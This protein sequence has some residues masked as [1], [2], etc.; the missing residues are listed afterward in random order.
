MKT[1]IHIKLIILA[2]LAFSSASAQVLFE[3]VTDQAGPFHRG[4]SW[5]ATW[6]DFNGDN[7]PDII[8]N[9]HRHKNSLWRNDCQGSFDDVMLTYDI[10]RTFI[11]DTNQDT[12]SMTVADVDNDGDQDLLSLRSSSGGRGQLFIYN[13]SYGDEQ[14]SSWD[15]DTC[16]GGRL[17]A[18]FDYDNDG[19]L[20]IFCARAGDIRVYRRNSNNTFSRVESTVG[21]QGQCSHNNYM[22]FGNFY[23]PSS[24]LDLSCGRL[25]TVPE[26]FYDMSTIPFNNVTSINS[27]NIS[28]VPDTVFADFDNDLDVDLFALKNAVRPSGA[29]RINS[30]KIESWIAVDKKSGQTF[31]DKGFRFTATGNVT[32]TYSGISRITNA[33]QPGKVYIGSSGYHPGSFPAVLDPTNSSNQG[34]SNSSSVGFFIGY[35]PVAQEWTALLRSPS[36]H[37][38]GYFVLDGTNFSEP[39]MFNLDNRDL[40]STPRMHTNNNGTLSTLFG[41]GFNEDISCGSIAAGDLDNDMDI[42]LY[43]ACRSGVENMEN[44]IYW[45]DGDGTF[46]K[47]SNHGGE[48]PVGAGLDSH[49]G[50]AESVVIADYDTDG[51][52]DLFVTN[53]NLLMPSYTGGPDVL[54]RN[55]G[56]NGNHWIELDLVGTNSNR[57]GIGAK[58]TATAGGVTQLREQNGGYHRDSQDHMR[59][60]FGLG[61]NTSVSVTVDWPDGSS[62]TYN[63]SDFTAGVD[64]LY[65]L[66]QGGNAVVASVGPMVDFPAPQPGD[67]CGSQLFES[68]SSRAIHMYKDC[69]SGIWRLRAVSGNSLTTIGYSG[70]IVSS[71][72]ITNVTGFSLEGS[73]VVNQ[74]TT[75][76]VAFSL[77]M[78]LTG[79]DGFDFSLTP[80][81]SSCLNVDLPQGAQLF[82]GDGYHLPKLPFN[83]ETLESCL[84][85]TSS[86]VTVSEAAGVAQVDVTLLG[87]SNQTI[88]VDYQTANGSATAG[89]DYTSGSG[90]L[91]FNPGDTVKSFN[92]PIINDTVLEGDETFTVAFSNAAGASLATSSITVTIEDNDSGPSNC[93]EPVIDTSVDRELFIWK[94]CAGNGDWH[95]LAT[96]GGGSVITYEGNLATDQTFSNV[97][98]VSIESSDVLDDSDPQQIIFKMKMGDVYRDGFNFSVAPGSTCLTLDL[99]SGM[100]VLVGENRTPLTSP[101]NIETLGACQTGLGVGDITVSE[102]D[103]SANVPVTLSSASGSIVTVEFQTVNGSATAGLDYT[104]GSGTVMFNPGET[105][106]SVNITILQDTAIEG[107]ENFTVQLSNPVNALISDSSGVV[108]IN[109]DDGNNCGEPVIDR[110]VDREI[111]IWQDCNDNEWHLRAYAGGGSPI[112]YIGNLTTFDSFTDVGLYSIESSDVVDTSDPKV[113]AFD[114]TMGD[115]WFDGIDFQVGVG[116]TCLTLNTPVGKDVLVGPNRQPVASPFDIK[117]LGACSSGGNNPPVVVNPGAQTNTVGASVSLFISATD[118][119]GDSLTYSQT[120]LPAGLDI[121]SGTGEITGAASSVGTS[122]VTVTASDGIASDSENFVWTIEQLPNVAPTANAG[123]N[124]TIVLPASVTLQGSASDDGLPNPPGAVTYSWSVISGPGTVTFAN[125]NAPDTTASFSVDG[126]YNLRLTVN[127]SALTDTDDVT[128]SVGPAPIACIEA[129]FETDFEGWINRPASTCSTGTFVRG[130]PA[131]FINGGVITQLGGDHTTGTGSALYT[132]VNT[133]S[134]GVNDVDNGECGIRSPDYVVTQDSDLSIWYFHGQRDNGDDPSGDYFEL[135][136]RINGGSWIDMVNIGDVTTNAAWTEATATIPA[137]STVRLRVRASDGSATGDLVEAGIDDLKICPQ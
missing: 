54:I 112:N 29:S 119:D 64:R 47:G 3:D 118:I 72:P 9:N 95:V 103:G 117:T 18:F 100:S 131:Q 50:V 28:N 79:T 52:L 26:R 63:N 31:T 22:Q 80:G 85:L 83:L 8:V 36:G 46:T 87:S 94:D 1:I 58:V 111:F 19:D 32:V 67:E 66:N 102:A 130:T 125:A 137:G 4:E 113:I 107:A 110:N 134:A 97:V 109:D 56:G 45:N 57:D 69:G 49:V 48:G 116:S 44:I 34:I 68:S 7:C 127:D 126:D 88:T 41:L 86:D 106:K 30:G 115:I 90:T 65:K 76:E 55:Q 108:T 13:G 20:D 60:H 61:S 77:S 24:G 122:N 73:D 96:A 39:V 124:Q 114:L 2:I 74:P 91:T 105:S 129:D 23:T 16:T 78:A 62:D 89:S 35:D 128:I 101:F 38:D 27:P 70:T 132:A 10:D 40:A 11:V 6:G 37:E 43:L 59:I 25:G 21:M 75:N 17:G 81:A 99:P 5:G 84:S 51:F 42:D 14:G 135:E 15:L 121:D 33:G 123:S 92:I 120:G 93:G 133:T 71:Q 12:H 53:G 136:Y 104:A 82:L 98:P